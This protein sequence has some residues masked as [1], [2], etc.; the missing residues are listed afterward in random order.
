M[1]VERFET[2]A[3][4]ALWTRLRPTTRFDKPKTH[5]W[6]AAAQRCTNNGSVPALTRLLVEL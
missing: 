4:P 5:P 2:V 3:P 6:V 1:N